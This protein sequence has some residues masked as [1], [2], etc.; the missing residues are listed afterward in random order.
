MRD[1]VTSGAGSVAGTGASVT[2]GAGPPHPGT[3]WGQ[4]HT[5]ICH[6]PD[7]SKSQGAVQ[8]LLNAFKRKHMIVKQ[9]EKS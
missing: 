3:S 9:D 2:T 5:L 8:K 6:C 7:L 4:L 1:V